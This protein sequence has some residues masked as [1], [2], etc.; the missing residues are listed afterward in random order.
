M[1]YSFVERGKYSLPYINVHRKQSKTAKLKIK[2][3]KTNCRETKT[4]TIWTEAST[5][6]IGSSRKVTNCLSVNLHRWI[7][8]IQNQIVPKPSDVQTIEVHD[9]IYAGKDNVSCLPWQKISS[10]GERPWDIPFFIRPPPYGWFFIREFLETPRNWQFNW[11]PGKGIFYWPP[12]MRT[13][14]APQE[15]ERFYWPPGNLTFYWPPGKFSIKGKTSMFNFWVT[16]RFSP[17]LMSLSN[18]LIP[19][20]QL[21]Y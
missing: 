20:V 9:Q 3:T 4:R 13:F 14:I 8:P 17:V 5:G 15:R 10:Q 21:Q 1:I 18:L 12:G 6:V 2:S 19:V 11:P 7:K 16:V